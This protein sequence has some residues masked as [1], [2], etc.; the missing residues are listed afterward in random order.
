MQYFVPFAVTTLA[1]VIED[2]LI[3]I[4]VGLAAG[5]FFVLR[6][7]YRNAYS[8]ERRESAD[9]HH[10]RLSL[11]Q[12]VTFLNKAKILRELNALPADAAVTIDGTRTRHLDMDVV[13]ILHDFQQSARRRGMTVLLRGIPAPPA[14]AGAH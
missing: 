11:A 1:I 9:H 8:Y 7:S 12:E 13:E 5:V 3:G 2:L 10:V 6:E 14:V 4:G